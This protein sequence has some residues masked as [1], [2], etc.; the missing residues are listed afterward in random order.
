MRNP[1]TMNIIVHH[2]TSAQGLT[3]LTRRVSEAHAL[4]IVS[5]V[6]NLNCPTEQKHRLLDAIR[7]DSSAD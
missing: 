7:D 6:Q 4:A 2:P 1:S 3:K 5:Y